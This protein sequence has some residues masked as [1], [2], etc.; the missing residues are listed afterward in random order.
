M[1]S[2]PAEIKNIW[3]LFILFSFSNLKIWPHLFKSWIALSTGINRYQQNKY[4]ENQQR[5]Q[6][7]SVLSTFRPTGARGIS[8]EDP[9]HYTFYK[10]CL[11]I[12]GWGS[13][14]IQNSQDQ[15]R[16]PRL[17]TVAHKNRI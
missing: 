2:I 6:L 5:Y 9:Q 10:K 11:T 8:K 1:D 17:I 15:S 16:R 3:S 4:Y 14:D 13:C 7:D 12:I